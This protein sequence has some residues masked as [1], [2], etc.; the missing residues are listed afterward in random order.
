MEIFIDD[1]VKKVPCIQWKQLRECEN[2]GFIAQCN[3]IAL[4]DWDILEYLG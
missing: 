3:Q 2:K 1:S 4:S